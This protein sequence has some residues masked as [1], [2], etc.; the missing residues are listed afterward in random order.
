ML[1][2]VHQLLDMLKHI[3]SIAYLRENLVLK[4]GTALNL[5][6]FDEIPRLSV[7]IDLNYIGYIDRAKMLQDRQIISDALK[8]IFY[9]KKFILYDN[10]SHP[11][12]HAGGKM[13]WGYTSVLGQ[14]GNI[15]V[16][17]NYMY[18]KPL[19]P[20]VQQKPK[21]YFEEEFLVPVLDIH[22]L[23]AGKLSALFTR[24]AS[25]D[26][27]DTYYLFTQSKLDTTKL[28]LAFVVYIA[29]T[30]IDI[31]KLNNYQLQYN[32]LDIRNKLLPVLRQQKLPR[33]SVELKKW[34]D[35]LL[36]KIKEQMTM[37]LPLQA[38]EQKFIELIREKGD[39][40]PDLITSDNNLQE[41]ILNHPAI[42]WSTIKS[43][44]KKKFIG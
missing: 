16:D 35:N 5:F 41:T 19:W 11:E 1:E 32:L 4:G 3:M 25:R 2:K 37:I 10:N 29:M 43:S 42:K 20:C 44:P 18:R 13:T 36:D 30:T 40:R 12:Q 28:R 26:L 14:G 27:F 31:S 33:K 8:Q 9:Q 23:A 7:D 21:L 17:L 22:E 15:E 39:I 38:E 34:A 24:N 6:S